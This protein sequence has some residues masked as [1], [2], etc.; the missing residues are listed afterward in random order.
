MSDDS[1]NSWFSDQD[2][3]FD[4]SILLSDDGNEDHDADEAFDAEIVT[5]RDRPVYQVDYTVRSTLDLEAMEKERVDRVSSMLGLTCQDAGTLLRHF[6]WDAD[7]LLDKYTE[8]P[9]DTLIDAGV[10]PRYDDDVPGT[11]RARVAFTC[12]I[13]FDDEDVKPVSAGCGHQFCDGCYTYYI[14]Q[15]I[16]EEGES[17][18]IC[19]PHEKCKVVVPYSLVMQLMDNSVQDRYCELLRQAFVDDIPTLRWCPA[20]DCPFAVE[21]HIP[22]AALDVVPPAV[23]CSCGHRFCFGCDLPDHQP[24]MCRLAKA[25]LKKC[26]DDSETAN[27]ITTHT[28]DCPRCSS[29]IEKNGGC[30]HMLCRKCRHEFCWVCYESWY[31]HNRTP[32][33]CNRYREDEDSKKYK[34]TRRE[35]L[36]RY[37]HYFNRFENHD[38]SAKLDEELYKKTEE[39]MLRMQETSNLSWIE[40]QFLKDAVNLAT[41]SRMTLKWSYAFAYYLENCHQAE[42]FEVNQEDLETATETLSELLSKTLDKEDISDF[43]QKILD[44]AAY[45]RQRRQILLSDTLQGLVDGR[46]AFNRLLE[47]S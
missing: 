33:S 32:H 47:N 2:S 40:V 34:E 41:Q 15:K 44:R 36:K 26:E 7:K 28:K 37:L 12:S 45:V 46:W 38:K 20:P 39:M 27:W 1:D 24:T 9:E 22:L 8:A 21:C 6:G 14:R 31:D 4:N 43:R 25:W 29:A 17:F 42:L 18:R 10:L 19:C 35:N 16:T 30:N 11:K 13:C 5:A 23:Q 3:A